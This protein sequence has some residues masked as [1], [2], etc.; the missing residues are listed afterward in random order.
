MTASAALTSTRR[1][2]QSDAYR[3]AV[4]QV[5]RYISDYGLGIN[6][7]ELMA[8]RN[9]A[10]LDERISLRIKPHLVQSMIAAS[11]LIK[12]GLHDPARREM[13]FLV[14]AA[15]KALWLDQGSPPSSGRLGPR[16]RS[17]A[18]RRSSSARAG[19]MPAT[20]RPITPTT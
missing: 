16:P 13:R 9:P 14:E 1:C 4:R 6:A 12:E 11:H 10:Y 15:V 18:A 8:R 3:G 7:I 2:A 5:D 17:C 20:P 19:A